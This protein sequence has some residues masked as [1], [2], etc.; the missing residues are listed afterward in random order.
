MEEIGRRLREAREARGITLTTAEEET[1][2]RRKYIEA[3]ESGREADLPGEAYL[4]GFLRTYGNYL[5]LDGPAL[6]ET[7]KEQRE[8][9]QALL[10]PE[11]GR[12][13]GKQELEW[14]RSARKPVGEERRASA[15]EEAR[16][17][18]RR[19][20]AGNSETARNAG[21]ALLVVA[22]V[23]VL[24]LAGWMIA[25]Q[26][27]SQA[28]PSPQPEAPPPAPVVDTKPA[29][30]PPPPP[31]LP[32]PPPPPKVTMTRGAGRDV[33]F[34]HPGAKEVEVIFEPTG[35]GVWTEVTI[36][37]GRP[38][39]RTLTT[40]TTFKGKEIRIIAGHMND[41]NL[42]VNGQRFEKPL[43]RSPVVH[44]LIFRGE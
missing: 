16:S 26:L 34:V 40:A 36:D 4:K 21:I 33:L 14:G 3:L 20:A 24:G 12:Q 35:G 11:A 23:A 5:G 41:V 2:I 30:P 13:P 38:V 10:E 43:D 17:A 31:K 6:V 7:Y 19:P 39:Q 28:E 32:D 8:A 27:G 29:D 18:P 15:A 9:A 1:K 25:G 37:G 44:H 42:V 22:V